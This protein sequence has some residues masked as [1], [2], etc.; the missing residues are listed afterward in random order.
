MERITC[1]ELRAGHIVLPEVLS[2]PYTKIV[3]LVRH[4]Q[5]THNSF[6]LTVEPPP[7]RCH[8][9]GSCAYRNPAH[10]D[11]ALTLVG[12]RQ[13]R[14]VGPCLLSLPRA[15]PEVAFASPLKR[16]LETAV[17]GLSIVS[18]T[19]DIPVIADERLREQHGRHICDRR[20]PV[21][22]VA[23]SFPTVDFARV[24]RGEDAAHDEHIREDKTLVARRAKDFFLS[25]KDMPEKSI[26]VFSHSA[27]YRTCLELVFHTPDPSGT[28]P[29]NVN[30]WSAALIH[31]LPARLFFPFLRSIANFHVFSRFLFDVMVTIFA[32]TAI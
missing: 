14:A 18:M 2:D 11:A 5:A 26:A 31:W 32:Q 8:V 19:A 7:C 28:S 25:L 29:K 23:S 6:A 3:H 13:A 22:D 21:S 15:A 1:V 24:Q 20:S 16:A 10:A 9:G 27:F 4:G 17:I 12:R 30:E